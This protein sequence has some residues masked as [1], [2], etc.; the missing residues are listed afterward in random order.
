M[1]PIVRLSRDRRTCGSHTLTVG[2]CQPELV[3]DFPGG[4]PRY[5]QRS[6]G[7]RA[8]LVNGQINDLEGEH[9]GVR[10]RG[11]S[12]PGIG[13]GLVS[14]RQRL[15]RARYDSGVY[16][17]TDS[18]KIDPERAAGRLYPVVRPCP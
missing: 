10:V 3:H 9:T 7:Y 8:T 18:A 14:D 16:S 1:E 12:T 4:A 13:S 6:R 5:I 11:T 17:S 15:I 2:E